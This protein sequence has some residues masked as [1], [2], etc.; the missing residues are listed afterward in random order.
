MCVHCRHGSTCPVGVY[1]VAFYICVCAENTHTHTY[2]LFLSLSPSHTLAQHKHTRTFAECGPLSK[3]A[4]IPSPDNAILPRAGFW[5]VCTYV[6]LYIYTCTR[7]H[8]CVCMCVCVCVCVFLCAC[9]CVCVCVY[10]C[11]RVCITGAWARTQERTRAHRHS[12]CDVTFICV[13]CLMQTH[14][15][16]QLSL[17]LSRSLSALEHVL[18]GIQPWKRENSS[19]RRSLRCFMRT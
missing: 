7:M 6:S 4:M 11:A 12:V 8:M 10:A 15:C 17:S 5:I 2:P 3:K 1:I 18:P 14:I 16:H 9:V 19:T 13:T